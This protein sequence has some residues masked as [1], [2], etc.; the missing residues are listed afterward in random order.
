MDDVKIFTTQAT[1]ITNPTLN[2]LL[3]DPRLTLRYDM[4]AGANN[5][6]LL[7]YKRNSGGSGIADMALLIPSSVFLGANVND[8]VYLYS[9]FGGDVTGAS[10]DSTS[11]AGFEEWTA[12]RGERTV[13]VPE[14]SSFLLGLIGAATLIA[15]RRR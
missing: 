10:A 4:D 2:S 3:T 11:D 13:V 9:R 6:V 8:T 14:P 1:G 15:R 5:T 12:G 7:D